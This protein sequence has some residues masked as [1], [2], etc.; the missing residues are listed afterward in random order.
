MIHHFATSKLLF[1]FDQIS[2]DP[3]ENVNWKNQVDVGN[4]AAGR[5]SAEQINFINANKANWLGSNG[6]T[7][8]DIVYSRC[9]FTTTYFCCSLV[10]LKKQTIEFLLGF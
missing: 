8:V 5:W 4:G 3:I 10:V 9:F 7:P 1:D 6:Q 2:F